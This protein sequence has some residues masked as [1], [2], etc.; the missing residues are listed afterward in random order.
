MGHA[1]GPTGATTSVPGGTVV[2]PGVV[3]TT[4][5]DPGGRLT[6]VVMVVSLTTVKG[7]LVP[8]IVTDVAPVNSVPVIVISV[9]VRAGIGDGVTLVMTGTLGTIGPVIAKDTDA[10]GMQETH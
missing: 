2:P 5:N 9:G 6:V 1:P 8:P 7:T 10:V 3:T 4:P